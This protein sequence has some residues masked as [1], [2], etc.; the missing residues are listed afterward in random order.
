MSLKERYYYVRLLDTQE[1]KQNDNIKHIGPKSLVTLQEALEALAS[2]A[3]VF[4]LLKMP[5][6]ILGTK[7]K[8]LD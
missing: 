8:D 1:E 3:N 2:S 5:A 7:W 6:P 4:L